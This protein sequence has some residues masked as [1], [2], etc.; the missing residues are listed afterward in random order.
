MQDQPQTF[1]TKL[2]IY[3]F[4]NGNIQSTSFQVSSRLQRSSERGMGLSLP[5]TKPYNFI[6]PLM[7]NFFDL[8]P[9][10]VIW[11]HVRVLFVIFGFRYL[12]KLQKHFYDP[13]GL[14]S[15][16]HTSIVQ[17]SVFVRKYGFYD[18]LF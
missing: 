17:G 6:I 9:Y 12:T 13:Y 5:S 10:S 7:A 14:I 18:F 4:Y 8:C 11:L 16:A 1:N 3:L 15:G 2:Q